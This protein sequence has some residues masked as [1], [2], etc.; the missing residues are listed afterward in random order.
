VRQRV[1]AVSGYGGRQCSLMATAA[2][3]SSRLLFF[4]SDDVARYH[5]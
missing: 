5:F 2:E 4:A 3:N 1:I